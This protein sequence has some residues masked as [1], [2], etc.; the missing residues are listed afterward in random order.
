MYFVAL[1]LY[2]IVSS[3]IVRIVKILKIIEFKV[4]LKLK[5]NSY[6]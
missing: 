1:I 5:T 4:N 6:L 3:K 2:N